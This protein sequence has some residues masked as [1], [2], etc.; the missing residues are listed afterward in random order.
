VILKK[1]LAAAQKQHQAELKAAKQKGAAVS[2]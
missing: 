1:Q 2:A